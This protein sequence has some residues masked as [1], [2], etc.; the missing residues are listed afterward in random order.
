[1]IIVCLLPLLSETCA[2]CERAL[3]GN[4][5]K[6]DSA[7]PLFTYTVGNPKVHYVMEFALD[8]ARVASA[9]ASP[10]CAP[11]SAAAITRIDIYIIMGPGGANAHGHSATNGHANGH[12]SGTSGAVMS[13]S[14]LGAGHW[15]PPTNRT[16]GS[17]ITTNSGMGYADPDRSL[18]AGARGDLVLMQAA[19]N[20]SLPKYLPVMQRVSCSAEHKSM[21]SSCSAYVWL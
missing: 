18:T 10:R 1:M 17:E 9:V 21:C 14:K 15:V 5:K 20:S 12:A 7:C 11:S 2:R 4:V 13:D 3:A 16:N 6:Y 19:E 8:P